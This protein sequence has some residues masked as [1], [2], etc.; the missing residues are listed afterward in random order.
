VNVLVKRGSGIALPH[1]AKKLH[2]RF[3]ALCTL[4]LYTGCRLNRRWRLSGLASNWIA[5]L[6]SSARPRMVY[7]VRFICRSSWY[8]CLER[9]I[10][11]KAA[12][13]SVSARLA[14]FTTRWTM[15]RK[16]TLRHAGL[17]TSA[18]VATGAWKSRAAAS[19][20]ASCTKWCKHGATTR[21]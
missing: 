11:P 21:T 1:E 8:I 2:A 14:G 4:L 3:G 5:A 6:L 12:R 18:L 10:G 15:P 7:R 9:G 13:C 20:Y 17:D 19:V 16:A